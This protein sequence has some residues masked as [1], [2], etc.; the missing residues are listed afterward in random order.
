MN[1]KRDIMI[2]IARYLNDPMYYNLKSVLPGG[3]EIKDI[4]D[5]LKQ[6][7]LL[8]PLLFDLMGKNDSVKEKYSQI[9]SDIKGNK[10][11]CWQELQRISACFTKGNIK[12]AMIKGAVL[13]RVLY[14]EYW[15]RKYGDIDILVSTETMYEA[16]RI[17]RD[18]GYMMV[19]DYK[20]EQRLDKPFVKERVSHELFPYSRMVDGVLVIVEIGYALHSVPGR[21]VSGMLENTEILGDTGI[22]VLNR[23]DMLLQIIDNTF[24][25]SFSHYSYMVGNFR[26]GDYLDL[27]RYIK[28]YEFTSEEIVAVGSRYH[29]EDM[30]V[31][32]MD[33]L[34]SIFP[35]EAVLLPVLE[36]GHIGLIQKEDIL[37]TTEQLGDLEDVRRKYIRSCKEKVYGLGNPYFLHPVSGIKTEKFEFHGKW[38]LDYGLWL[39]ED[40]ICIH[41]MLHGDL[42]Q[43]MD[44]L[45]FLVKIANNNPAS[46]I[47]SNNILIWGQDRQLFYLFKDDTRDNGHERYGDFQDMGQGIN[48]TETADGGCEFTVRF[49]YRGLELNASVF[50]ACGI[51]VKEKVEEN[52]YYIIYSNYDYKNTFEVPLFLNASFRERKQE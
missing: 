45:L 52:I 41:F 43:Q 39:E 27:M 26:L 15:V 37:R 29:M 17:L 23:E 28:K 47:Y 34:H 40:D 36:S 13:S 50:I 24:D 1:Y 11:I 7:R 35:M 21:D 46:D 49:P 42:L 19:N 14:G 5:V 4:V 44:D 22:P 33:K 20:I 3:M 9:L 30:V 2:E 32:V 51:E 16:D 6:Q 25:N 8:G 10:A 18:L 48:G 31:C 12:F 38:E